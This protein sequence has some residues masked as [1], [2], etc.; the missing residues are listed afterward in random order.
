[1]ASVAKRT[2][3][4]KG[5]EKTA[6]VV[7]YV[8][9]GGRHRSRQFDMKKQADTYKR[10]VEN[11]LDAGSHVARRD[12][13][14]VR[15]LCAEFAEDVERRFS[16]GKI[17]RG[18]V[19]L[20]RNTL[21]YVTPVLGTVLVRD[22]TWQDVERLSI[23][24]RTTLT[25]Y[26]RPL[27]R[28]TQSNIITLFGTVV[29]YAVRRGYA[30]RNVVPDAQREIGPAA[31]PA[32]DKF[33]RD[34]VRALLTALETPP[35][36]THRRVQAQ[37]KAAVYL[38]VVCGLRRGEIMGL[39][40]SHIDFSAGVVHVRQAL[41]AWDNVKA[42]KTSAGVRSVPLPLPV[43]QAILDYLPMAETDHRGLIFRGRGGEPWY[44]ASWTKVWHALLLRSGFAPKQEGDWR[45]FH[46][47]RHFAGSAWLEAGVPLAEVSKLMGHAH[48]GVT[49]QV[50]AHAIVGTLERA[51]EI[52]N[53]AASL[54][55]A[56][57]PIAQGLRIAA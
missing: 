31:V 17:G 10:E 18:Y 38:A 12:S 35:P 1:M 27:T 13:R 9:R 5:A 56:P 47:L 7:R 11:E 32:I 8:D 37:L 3:T 43:A 46:A 52:G 4:Y 30:A 53:V 19:V 40:L 57:R 34:E 41:D 33:S 36:G 28:S 24:L 50:Y 26:G 54:L 42:P 2:W 21:K 45:H 22:M 48:M 14:T 15:D 44:S 6:W 29:G 25:R 51:K 49:A 39:T 23:S 20:V 16:D 55:P